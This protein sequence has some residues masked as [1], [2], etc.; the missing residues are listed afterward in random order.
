[1]HIYFYRETLD[2]ELDRVSSKKVKTILKDVDYNTEIQSVTNPGCSSDYGYDS[3]SQDSN[4][5][6]MTKHGIDKL[7][8]SKFKLPSETG[9]PFQLKK[10]A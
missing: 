3:V 8:Y 9:R 7:G 1:M 4:E 6:K 2:D 5:E 10:T